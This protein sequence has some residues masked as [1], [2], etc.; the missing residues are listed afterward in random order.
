VIMSVNNPCPSLIKSK[1]P[2]FP[3][4]VYRCLGSKVLGLTDEPSEVAEV[5][6]ALFDAGA[7][8]FFVGVD[9]IVLFHFDGAIVEFF[10]GVGAQ[11]ED[12]SFPVDWHLPPSASVFGGKI[13]HSVGFDAPVGSRF[14]LLL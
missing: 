4:T 1:S 13:H 14:R 10:A 3:L 9:V 5:S 6:V 8:D 2:S 11:V 12:F 7:E